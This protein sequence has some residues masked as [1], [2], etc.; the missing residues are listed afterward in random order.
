LEFKSSGRD[1][2][3]KQ[4]SVLHDVLRRKGQPAWDEVLGPFL[5]TLDYRDSFAYRWWPLGRSAPIVVDPEY[6]WGFPVVVGSGVRTEILFERNS[7]GETIEEI[8]QDFGLR[9][10]EVRSAIDYEV[11]LAA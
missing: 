11:R 3:V 9:P 4:D 5:E 10:D 7:A 1:I 2:F 6:G 8:A